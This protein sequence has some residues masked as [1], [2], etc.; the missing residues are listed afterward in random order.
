MNDPTCP[1][2]RGPDR[3]VVHCEDFASWAPG[4]HV[5]GSSAARRTED[6]GP[7]LGLCATCA[8]IKTCALRALH[9][10]GR[11]VTHCEELE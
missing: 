6:D 3:P 5:N 2:P 11:P 7:T 9:E 1:F 4:G 10:P 8:K